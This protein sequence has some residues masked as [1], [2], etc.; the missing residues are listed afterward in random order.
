MTIPEIEQWQP[1]DMD[2]TIDAC[3]D[4]TRSWE[5]L[6]YELQRHEKLDFWQGPAADAARASIKK[7]RSDLYAHTQS[8]AQA[9]RSIQD[10]ELRLSRVKSNLVG[11][12]YFASDHG[13]VIAPN[14]KVTAT[15]DGFTSDNKSDLAAH[16][17]GRETSRADLEHRLMLLIAEASDIDSDLAAALIDAAGGGALTAEGTL[18][19]SIDGAHG[20]RDGQLLRNGLPSQADLSVITTR[21]S[22]L[23]LTSDQLEA[24]ALGQEVTLPQSQ[25]D[26]LHQFYDSAGKDGL[27]RLSEELRAQ[28]H[29]GSTTAAGAR[30]AL[31]NNLLVLSNE[32]V[33]TASGMRGG[34]NQLPQDIQELVKDPQLAANDTYAHQVR[35]SQLLGEANP[36]Y[37]GGQEFSTDVTR[38]AA[39]LAS[40]DV[41]EYRPSLASYDVDAFSYD[42]AA[43]TLLDISSRNTDASLQILSGNGLD[44]YSADDTVM[45]LLTHEWKDEGESASK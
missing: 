15:P 18:D 42:R 11:E 7:T 35:F 29:A 1:G 31:A 25:L 9:R 41:A 40:T 28:E 12:Q 37:I 44:N 10:A 4:L 16:L 8:I 3:T 38:T 21:L 22:E 33:T 24:L 43:E 39:L 23:H 36:G 14:G 6:D 45:K 17:A 2:A 5:E 13:F 32:D 20:T 19:S 27:F 34:M 30:D 26:Y